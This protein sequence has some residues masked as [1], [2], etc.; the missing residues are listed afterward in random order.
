[1]LDRAINK[2]KTPLIRICAEESGLAKDKLSPDEWRTL[3][4][5]RDFLQGFYDTTK[6]NEGRRATLDKVLPSLDF[7]VN[8]FEQ[9]IKVYANDEFMAASLHAG[10]T[11]SLLYWNRSD[12]SPVYIAAIVLDP[13]LK[14][15]YFDDWQADWQPNLKGSMRR[16]WETNYKP[17]EVTMMARQQ[18]NPM[19]TTNNEFLLWMQGRRRQQ[20][21]HTMADE[22]DQYLSEPLLLQNDKTAL[23]WWLASEQQS[24]F[25]YL[26][27]MAIDIYSIPAMSSEPERVF[28]GAKH[29]LTD[30]RMRISIEVLELLECLKSWF[31]IGIFTETDLHAIIA[32]EQQLQAEI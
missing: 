12:R 22:L 13:T 7:M 5:I 20:N 30:Q 6:A 18:A 14:W 1:M 32:A 28:S 17:S 27:K 4:N 15:S 16:F 2:L 29:T 24:R 23:D 31:K 9:A 3:S 26:S 8:R 21:S 10:W 25:P 19:R 11:K